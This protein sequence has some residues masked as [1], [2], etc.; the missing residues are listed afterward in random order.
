M[1]T[2]KL[3]STLSATRRLA[4]FE[5]FS[6]SRDPTNSITRDRSVSLAS[7]PKSAACFP[8]ASY[9]YAYDTISFVFFPAR[10][11]HAR[12]CAVLEKRDRF[13]RWRVEEQRKSQRGKVTRGIFFLE[14]Q[15][16]DVFDAFRALRKKKGKKKK[17]REKKEERSFLE[18][19]SP[20]PLVS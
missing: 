9:Y 12:V 13:L 17:Q 1:D 8:N 6:L 3:C 10:D 11:I 19:L 2:R 7:S 14:L 20:D 15:T 5:T 16:F 18:P 4:E